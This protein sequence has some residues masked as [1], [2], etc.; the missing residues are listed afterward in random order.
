MYAI[1]L[2]DG[3]SIFDSSLSSI[4]VGNFRWN[5][6]GKYVVSCVSGMRSSGMK[7]TIFVF[8]WVGVFGEGGLGVFFGLSVGELVGKGPCDED[9][10]NERHGLCVL[11]CFD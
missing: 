2:K 9:L 5:S 3:T 6:E 10:Q 8:F 4:L 11:G 1:P 7:P